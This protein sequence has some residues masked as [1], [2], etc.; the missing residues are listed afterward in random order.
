MNFKPDQS[1]WVDFWKIF[2]AEIYTHLV[3]TIGHFH[4]EWSWT[5]V[6]QSTWGFLSIPFCWVVKSTLADRLSVYLQLSLPVD[7]PVHFTLSTRSGTVN[8]PEWSKYPSMS[9]R[10][11]VYHPRKVLSSRYCSPAESSASL[12][13]VLQS[14]LSSQNFFLPA[15]TSI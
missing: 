12:R 14:I 7:W 5:Y 8:F 11:V 3:Y 15:G 6:K 9:S 4:L 1:T 10:S 13:T 2:R